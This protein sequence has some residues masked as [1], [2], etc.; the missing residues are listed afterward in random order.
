MTTKLLETLTL[1]EEALQ[2]SIPFS[3]SPDGYVKRDRALAAIREQKAELEK[4]A[5]RELVEFTD[6]QPVTQEPAGYALN[7]IVSAHIA[8]LRRCV[9]ILM[10]Y[11]ELSRTAKEVEKAANELEAVIQEQKE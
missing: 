6:E 3:G 5:E 1:A 7:K 11:P 9:P 10:N 2:K 8:D 4:Q